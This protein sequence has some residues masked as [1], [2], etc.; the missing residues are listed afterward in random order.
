MEPYKVKKES[1]IPPWLAQNWAV[2]AILAGALVLVVGVLLYDFWGPKPV[3]TGPVAH[4]E[5]VIVL[6]PVKMWEEGSTTRLKGVQL[7]IKNRGSAP[8]DSVK[9]TGTFRGIS[10]PLTGKAIL[11]PGEIGDYSVTFNMVV[12]NSDSMEFKAE[13]PSCSPFVPPAN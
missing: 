2:I 8:A 9:V 1:S 6:G 3:Q 10:L 4:G 12:L 5:L 13:C 11:M 7:K